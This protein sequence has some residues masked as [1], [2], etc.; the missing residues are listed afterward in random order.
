[1]I[2][3]DILI[4]VSSLIGAAIGA[5]IGV[6]LAWHSVRNDVLR[7]LGEHATKGSTGL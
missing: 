4:F 3:G 7:R 1:M 6:W 2:L 5:I